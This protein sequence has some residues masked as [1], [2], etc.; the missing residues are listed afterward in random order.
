[1]STTEGFPKLKVA[2]DDAKKIAKRHVGRKFV[3]T[4][5]PFIKIITKQKQGPYYG[6]LAFSLLSMRLLHITC[7][8]IQH[9]RK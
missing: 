2:V 6:P 3:T 5:A 8:L 7:G 1:M 4:I 9:Q